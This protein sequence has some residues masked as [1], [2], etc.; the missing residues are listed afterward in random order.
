ML[1]RVLIAL[2]LLA[3]F[4]AVVWLGRRWYERRN[5]RIE[6]RL[7]ASAAAG[8]ATGVPATAT[9]GVEGAVHENG[10][11]GAPRIVYFTT[12]SCLVCKTQQEPAIDTLRDE[13][14]EVVIEQYDAVQEA[15]LAKEYGVLLVPTTAVYDRSGELVAIN[16]GF[17]PAVRL[18]AQVEG[19]AAAAERKTGARASSD[20]IN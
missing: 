2:A 3:L 18:R 8:T 4:A 5:A 9:A 19:R 11:T 13:V 17:A 7:R 10:S 6:E 1:E 20:H 16:R 12:R 15:D 14:P